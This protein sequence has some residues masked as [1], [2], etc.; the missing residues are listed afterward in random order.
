LRRCRER[1]HLT[2][3]HGAIEGIG[4]RHR[5]DQD[6]HDQAHAFLP[7]VGTVEEAHQRASEDEDSANPP[8][9]GMIALG[10]GIERGNS[11]DRF[12]EQQQ[13]GGERKA[14]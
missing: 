8:W 11:D 14:K 5:A 9:R 10:L 13:N 12:Q 3:R 7:I 1:P 2:F 4:R 6:Q